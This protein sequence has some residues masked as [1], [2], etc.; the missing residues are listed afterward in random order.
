M[1]QFIPD[2]S[3][4][5]H[6]L[7]GSPNQSVYVSM[8]LTIYT[9]GGTESNASFCEKRNLAKCEHNE[10]CHTVLQSCG[11]ASTTSPEIVS[12]IGTSQS[13]DEK[14][15]AKSRQKAIEGL[16]ERGVFSISD[17]TEADE[18]CIFGTRFVDHVKNKGTPKAF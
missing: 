5:D 15:Y 3:P 8:T 1:K 13:T 16:F 6:K 7:Q 4:E 10:S 11:T 18:V 14:K 17:K 2:E 9:D 12:L